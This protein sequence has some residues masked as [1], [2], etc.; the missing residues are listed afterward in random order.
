MATLGEIHALYQSVS[1]DVEL[2]GATREFLEENRRRFR[3]IGE[4]FLQD[5]KI[6]FREAVGLPQD[7]PFT[8]NAE[9]RFAEWK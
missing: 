3:A 7:T 4:A 6:S 2:F 9:A 5:K 8:E 1:N